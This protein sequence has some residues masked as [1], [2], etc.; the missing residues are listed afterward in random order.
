MPQENILGRIISPEAIFFLAG[1][2]AKPV[3]KVVVDSLQA[4]RGSHQGRWN[5]Y[6]LLC[7]ASRSLPIFFSPHELQNVCN[8]R[9]RTETIYEEIKDE[10]L[11]T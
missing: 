1:S 9:E 10:N 6:G 3:D 4:R 7:V 11:T 8:A 5:P 2:R